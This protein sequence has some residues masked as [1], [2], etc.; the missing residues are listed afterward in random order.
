MFIPSSATST[1][2]SPVL[3]LEFVLDGGT[4]AGAEAAVGVGAGAEAEPADGR[5]KSCAKEADTRGVGDTIEVTPAVV[6]GAAASDVATIGVGVGVG[7][8]DPG[9]L[10][11]SPILGARGDVLRLPFPFPFPLT[12]P[13][14]FFSPWF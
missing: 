7:S 10:S 11:E 2:P 3:A 13:F 12:F 1:A 6:A 9:L 4:G 5:E 8:D 14:P